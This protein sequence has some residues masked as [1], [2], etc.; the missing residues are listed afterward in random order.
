VVSALDALG[1]RSP[2]I[3]R[4]SAASERRRRASE[5]S[6]HRTLS[7]P[8]AAR[9]RTLSA[10]EVDADVGALLRASPAGRERGD[11]IEGLPHAIRRI[12]QEFAEDGAPLRAVAAAVREAVVDFGF[13]RDTAS[14]VARSVARFA[15]DARSSA[16]P[17]GVAPIADPGAPRARRRT[18]VLDEQSITLLGLDRK[19][20]LGDGAGSSLLDDVKLSQAVLAAMPY[21]FRGAPAWRLA[22][23]TERDGYSLGTLYREADRARAACEWISTPGQLLLVR[24]AGEG[25][26]LGAFCG[27]EPLRPR[28]AG[29]FGTGECFLFGYRGAAGLDV[30]RPSAGGAGVSNQNYIFSSETHLGFGAGGPAGVEGCGLMLDEALDRGSSWPCST[31]QMRAPLLPGLHDFRIASVELW[32]TGC[33]WEDTMGLSPR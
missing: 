21:R 12:A 15:V 1:N 30:F 3:Q 14:A 11:S 2:R 25:R 17:P 7:S 13:G 19:D 9:R 4:A 22:F 20:S 16:C 10:K 27:T 6:A 29:F 23:S 26:V 24:E 31:F 28:G 8:R 32:F 33:S 18:V 5:A